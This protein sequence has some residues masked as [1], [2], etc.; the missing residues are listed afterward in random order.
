MLCHNAEVLVICKSVWRYRRFFGSFRQSLVCY[1][2]KNFQQFL[3]RELEAQRQASV[4]KRVLEHVFQASVII[5]FQ[6]RLW[7]F[8]DRPQLNAVLSHQS[9]YMVCGLVKV[10][11]TSINESLDEIQVANCL[12]HWLVLIIKC[13]LLPA[14]LI[15][16]FCSAHHLSWPSY[17]SPQKLKLVPSYLNAESLNACFKLNLSQVPIQCYV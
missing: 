7:S 10:Y 15:T 1:D 4:D 13:H 3:L 16:R 6:G 5:D 17:G 11:A 14:S 8:T 12:S 2:L 9:F